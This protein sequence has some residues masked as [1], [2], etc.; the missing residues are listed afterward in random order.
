MR[1]FQRTLPGRTSELLSTKLSVPHPNS[2]L[3]PREALFTVLDGS[4]ELPLT[5]LCAPAGSGKTTLASAWIT[6]RNADQERFKAAWLSL[7]AEDNDPVCFWRYMIAACQRFDA[8]VGAAS[9]QRLNAGAALP[10]ELPVQLPFETLLTWLINDLDRLAG[11]HVL[12]LEDYHML[13]FSQLHQSFTYFLEHLPTT[14]HIILLSRSDPP[15]PLARWRAQGVLLE[16]QASDMHFSPEETRAFFQQNLSLPLSQEMITRLYERT[17]GWGAGLHL[18]AL[19]LRRHTESQE[20]ERFITTLT[21]G[22]RPFLEYLVSDVLNMQP[23]PLQTFLLQTSMLKRLTA[24]LCDMVTGRSDSQ[25]LIEQI[26]RANLFLEPLDGAGEWYRYHALFAEAMQHEARRRSGVEELR[27]CFRQASLWYEQHHYMMEAIEAAL[28]AEDFTHA[29]ILIERQNGPL[30]ASTANEL[31]TLQRWFEQIPQTVLRQYPDLYL[32]FIFTVMFD[33]NGRILTSSAQFEKVETLLQE[34]EKLWQEPQ[35]LQGIY[36]LRALLAAWREDFKRAGAFAR[37]AL[38]HQY[39]IAQPGQDGAPVLLL[40]AQEETP[41][42]DNVLVETRQREKGQT[43]R[44]A[45][46]S[47]VAAEELFFGSLDS[48]LELLQEALELHQQAEGSPYEDRPI[49]LALAE[50]YIERGELIL[51]AETYHHILAEVGEDAFDHSK[52]LLGLARLSYERDMLDAACQ[53]AQEARDLAH[54]ISDEKLEV[55][56]EVMLARVMCAQGRVEQASQRFAEL[57]ARARVHPSP[58]LYRETLFFAISSIRY[59][60]TLPASMASPHPLYQQD[61]YSS[62]VRSTTDFA[63]DQRPERDDLL[64][65]F[66]LIRED[67]LVVRR[68]LAQGEM[69]EA[70][71]LLEQC[72]ARAQQHGYAGCML[73]AQMLLALVHFRQS[74][75]RMARSI[76]QDVLPQAR[77]QGYR[78]L[79]LDEGE[80]MAALLRACGE[81]QGEQPAL[82]ASSQVIEPLSVQEQRVLRLFVAGLSKAE[83]AN[84]LVI[85]INTVKTHLQRIYRKLNVTNRA[86]ARDVVRRLHLL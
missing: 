76:L 61:G 24:S 4:L 79:F 12:V 36:T 62:I 22:Y 1:E 45:C 50:A 38:T 40:P 56:A 35:Y 59:R 8:N 42:E 74:N 17:E 16:L 41:G 84:E 81:M 65:L 34:G 66:M 53:Q 13:T 10:F 25:L 68:L 19:A 60:E 51:A 86:E 33:P 46:L 49:R 77:S 54:R 9:L 31:Y 72:H 44:S 37:Q 47:L 63:T 55:Q 57:V 75:L 80:S 23:E 71:L 5:L 7:D 69:R 58:L 52:A 11:Q 83:I 26:E 28:M 48:A 18:A 2:A 3:V 30:N 21:G 85:S 82:A 20:Q 43:W 15:L 67:L 32:L 64:P 78:R 73:E 14:I 70:L 6:S 29:A 39:Q 27:R